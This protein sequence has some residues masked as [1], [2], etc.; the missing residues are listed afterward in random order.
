MKVI[1]L[2]N[3][4]K[5]A[6]AV[7][8]LGFL[9]YLLSY[10][11]L[12]LDSP[13]LMK[14]PEQSLGLG[15]VSEFLTTQGLNV[16][17]VVDKFPDDSLYKSAVTWFGDVH[18]DPSQAIQ[19][20]SVLTRVYY[21]DKGAGAN[22]DDEFDRGL[23]MFSHVIDRRL[24]YDTTNPYDDPQLWDSVSYYFY[25]SN[26]P[27]STLNSNAYKITLGFNGNQTLY[28]TNH[29]KA[30]QDANNDGLWE[31]KTIDGYC[32]DG[33]NIRVFSNYEGNGTNAASDNRGWRMQ[34]DLPFNF[35]ANDIMYK[36]DPGD[37][38][39]WAIE[40]NDKDS[41]GGSVSQE[42][43]PTGANLTNPSTWAQ[44]RF[45]DDNLTADDEV[46]VPDTAGT[47]GTVT[48]INNVNGAVTEDIAVGGGSLCGALTQEEN[49]DDFR[50]SSGAFAAD[51]WGYRI[52]DDAT[53]PAQY[54]FLNIQNQN[55]VADWPCFSRPYFK[56]PTT[57]VP[58]GKVIESA[59][60]KLFQFGNA[61]PSLYGAPKTSPTIVE[62]N[63]E[64]YGLAGHEDG[65]F[66]GFYRSGGVWDQDGPIT[67]GI[68]SG[69]FGQE[70]DPD[71]I[72]T[73]L[74]D[75]ANG[76]F[77]LVGREDGTFYGAEW[78]GDSW[79]SAP[80]IAGLGDLGG[81]TSPTLFTYN[82][83]LYTIV[84]RYN[85]GGSNY[86]L[87]AYRWNSVGQTWEAQTGVSS[88]IN[89][90]E[91]VSS[92]GRMDPDVFTLSGTLYMIIGNQNGTM[93]GYQFNGT[94]W[95]SSSAIV[96]G[97]QDVGDEAKPDY[98]V[99][100]DGSGS[101]EYLL[102][103]EQDDQYYIYSFNSSNQ[104]QLLKY[105]PM[106][107][108]L[109]AAVSLLQVYEVN[110]DVEDTTMN[111]NNAPQVT[112]NA[113]A[114]YACDIREYH[115]AGYDD[116]EV[117]QPQC[118]NSNLTMAM[119]GSVAHAR[120]D[121]DVTRLVAEAYEDSRSPAKFAVYT[122]D[123]PLHSGKYFR[124]SET[125]DPNFRPQLTIVYGE[126][127]T[128]NQAPT[129]QFTQSGRVGIS[130]YQVTFNA[131]A[132]TDS[133]GTIAS[134]SWNFDDGSSGTGQQ[135]SHTFN[136]ADS[137]DV[138]LTVTD[139]DGAQST[140]TY[141]VS[142]CQVVPANQA[143]GRWW[144]IRPNYQF[145]GNVLNC[146]PVMGSADGENMAINSS[147]VEEI[148]KTLELVEEPTD[149]EDRSVAE[150]TLAMINLVGASSD[151]ASDVSYLIN[152]EE[153]SSKDFRYSSF[154]TVLYSPRIIN[155]LV[156]PPRL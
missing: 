126:P 146:G 151:S 81:Y 118:E 73:T 48:I 98:F 114:A 101:D 90:L 117:H 113:A 80:I 154:Y 9:V 71:F 49:V 143:R 3:K 150:N 91:S 123:L 135:V 50:Y 6:T 102:V 139:N 13:E 93:T 131:S 156:Q 56:F 152:K 140:V 138:T 29:L 85:S 84:S 22:G 96:S 10:P 100:N 64:T 4:A 25:K 75:G 11:S 40:V 119:D 47:S 32:P 69:T 38:W 79:A 92:S 107:N 86:G 105:H 106:N 95:S 44:M 21:Y 19:N 26:S 33:C 39:R 134:Y 104:W 16:P 108:G 155:E 77:L 111:W 55:N 31:P 99:H 52:Y 121:I 141:L 110:G 1:G 87:L 66:S 57:P 51:G 137:Y 23:Q 67:A 153:R 147:D 120:I 65:E 130:P 35:F 60:L 28:T 88:M 68:A 46:Y 8:S 36:P 128:P 78:D 145:S 61:G 62:L 30:W 89:G 76:R 18:E 58:S 72:R 127:G 94:A 14:A 148:I 5:V 115:N 42:R 53:L 54:E 41:S 7:I 12:V 132:S 45:G 122:A 149:S 74:F 27:G 125:S 63:G 34:I 37:I 142:T 20:N 70:A 103:G 124:S 109:W 133:D 97:L 112:Q 59:T 15:T 17:F 83:N 144:K 129:A 136:G 24:Y 82:S 2:D 43:W 116:Q